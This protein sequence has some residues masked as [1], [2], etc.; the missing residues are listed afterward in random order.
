[1]PARTIAGFLLAAAMVGCG[2]GVCDASL[3]R[4][5]AA[6]EPPPAESLVALA[7]EVR[8]AGGLVFRGEVMGARRSLPPLLAPFGT[9]SVVYR[10]LGATVRVTDDLGAA[11]PATVEIASRTG[12]E[13]VVDDRGCPVNLTS[14]GRPPSA[15]EEVPASGERVFFVYPN[16]RD[17]GPVMV[18]NA[19]ITGDRVSNEGT[20]AE[21][22]IPIAALRATP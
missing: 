16:V 11:T 5:A 6:L 12:M 7:A 22:T 4:S 17:E 13:S 9:G 1:M 8:R 18:W 2:D 15:R 19:A 3:V 14:S 10:R 21:G 20:R